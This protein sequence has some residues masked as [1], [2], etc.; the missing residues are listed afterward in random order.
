MVV[1]PILLSGRGLQLTAFNSCLKLPCFMQSFQAFSASKLALPTKGSL[2]LGERPA[3]TY[4]SRLRFKTSRIWRNSRGLNTKHSLLNRNTCVSSPA[5]WGWLQTCLALCPSVTG[6]FI[7]SRLEDSNM[8][9][10]SNL[11]LVESAAFCFLSMITVD[12]WHICGLEVSELK[13][14]LYKLCWDSPHWSNH[15]PF[16]AENLEMLFSTLLEMYK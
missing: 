16:K 7:I 2:G 3:A 11:T 9:F 12:I 6:A 1:S 5:C 14:E 15:S 8:A 4:Y 10:I 13:V